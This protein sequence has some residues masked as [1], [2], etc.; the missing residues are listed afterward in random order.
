MGYSSHLVG[1]LSCAFL[2]V[3]VI[4]LRKLHIWEE[5]LAYGIL[6]IIIYV[7]FLTW[8]QVTAPAGPKSVPVNGD[9]FILASLMI[10]AY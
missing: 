2:L 9:P 1:P 6:S 7:I 8:A 10:G 5:F 4:I 3:A